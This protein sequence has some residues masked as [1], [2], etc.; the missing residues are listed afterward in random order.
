M[1]ARRE[2]ILDA[3][4]ELIAMGGI[5]GVSMRKLARR[6]DLSV[7]TLYNLFGSRE[8]ILVALAQRFAGNVERLVTE[9][10][11][12]EDPL[13]RLWA[14]F[15]TGIAELAENESTYRP[16]LLALFRGTTS[17]PE[18]LDPVWDRL[19][20][21]VA[22]SLREAIETGLL[23][24]GMSLQTLT[25]HLLEAYAW[26]L[27]QWADGFIDHRQLEAR[28]LY[29]LA[30]SLLALASDEARPRLRAQLRRC[31]AART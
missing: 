2:R 28:S 11:T 12:L 26:N 9:D 24:P 5:D 21:M 1:Q 23:C 30:L 27:Q 31:E 20:S 13:E 22:P 8:D 10:R 3:T 18:V 15:S 17:T 6:T 25:A 7:Q 29:G 16:I 4:L 19:A 14:M